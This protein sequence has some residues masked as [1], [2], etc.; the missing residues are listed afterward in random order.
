MIMTYAQTAPRFRTACGS[1]ASWLAVR[2]E[3]RDGVPH[4]GA[5]LPRSF[6][7]GPP[8]DRRPV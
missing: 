3:A 8:K 1:A 2:S 5:Q 4:A 7:V 6:E